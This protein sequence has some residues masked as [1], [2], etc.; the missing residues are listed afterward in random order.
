MP[1][2]YC[3]LFQAPT[4]KSTLPIALSMIFFKGQNPLHGLLIVKHDVSLASDYLLHL[5][6]ALCTPESLALGYHR[7]L[8]L[9][10]PPLKCQLGAPNPI[11]LIKSH[12]FFKSQLK[13]RFLKEAFPDYCSHQQR[14][15]FFMVCSTET[16]LISLVHLSHCVI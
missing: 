8:A 6:L 12:L 3:T 4:K 5:L 7:T 15:G 13:L 1:F 2:Q 14:S 11:F 16:C 10:V 9:A